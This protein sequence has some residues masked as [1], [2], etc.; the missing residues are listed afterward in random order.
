MEVCTRY[1]AC[2]KSKCVCKE[3][4]KS[5]FECEDSSWFRPADVEKRIKKGRISGDGEK[6]RKKSY[7]ETIYHF[8]EG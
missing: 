1:Q 2:W 3:S 6:R 7:R 4:V 8:G 5:V